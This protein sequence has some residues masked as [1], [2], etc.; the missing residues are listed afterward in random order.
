MTKPDVIVIGGGISGLSTAVDLASRGLS[1]LILEQ[2]QHLGGRAY[3]FA[4]KNT[5]EEIDNGQHLMMGCY[6]ETRWLLRTIGSD[7]LATLQPNL[8]IDF[9]HPELGAA[10]LHCP[11]LPAPFHLLVGLLRL[12]TLSLADR[13]KLLRIGLEIR[14]HPST[15]EP[16]I[17]LLTVDQWL[18]SL[19]QSEA[20]R[21]YLWDIIAVGSL[22]GDPKEVSACT[23]LQNL[24]GGVSRGQ[25]EFF[26]SDSEGWIKPAVR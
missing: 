22:N 16:A 1:V 10:S 4:D 23:L 7:R 6:H 17:A 3:S 5:G 24:E 21:K 9:R 8:H 18:G 2:H 26:A 14:K 15:I 20:N 12:R 11:S 19:G 13:L 25:G